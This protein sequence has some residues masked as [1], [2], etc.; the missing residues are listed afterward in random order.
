MS[1]EIICFVG[2]I[3]LVDGIYSNYVK[4]KILVQSYLE[5]LFLYYLFVLNPCY[6]QRLRMQ[7]KISLLCK[8]HA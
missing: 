4:D 5:F 1:G 7:A 8:P 3:S 6:L 2:K